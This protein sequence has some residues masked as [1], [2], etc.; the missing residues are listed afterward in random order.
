MEVQLIT[1]SPCGWNPFLKVSLALM[2]LV[3][4]LWEIQIDQYIVGS[5]LY[6]TARGA[7][8]PSD[9]NVAQPGNILWTLS[10]RC[11]EMPDFQGCTQHK[12]AT[13]KYEV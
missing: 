12:P 2:L 7:I 9:L 8:T 4:P 13:G 6:S 1:D 3:G 11:F 10:E 5:I